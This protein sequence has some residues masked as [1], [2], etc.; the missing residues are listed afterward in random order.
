[1]CVYALHASWQQQPC[2]HN[3]PNPPSAIYV[4][5]QPCDLTLSQATSTSGHVTLQAEI[6]P[7]PRIP[8]TLRTLR[9][10]APLVTHNSHLASFLRCK[11]KSHQQ[12]PPHSRLPTTF[13]LS[14]SVVYEA[15]NAG[16]FFSP[17]LFRSLDAKH[18]SGSSQLLPINPN[19]QKGEIL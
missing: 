12:I 4:F 11:E 8:P 2:P 17:L 14:E 6:C 5:A 18:N 3:P 16:I 7:L 1:M 13:H 10:T 19:Y 15:V 9:H